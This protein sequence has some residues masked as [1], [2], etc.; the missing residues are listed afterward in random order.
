MTDTAESTPWKALLDAWDQQQSGYLLHRERRFAAVLDA[1][2]HAVDS[3][4]ESAAP[5]RILDLGCGPGSFS[6]R[7][8]TR[9]PDAE[10]VALDIDPVLLAIGQGA[11]GD[12]DGRLTWVD[13][14]LRIPNWHT[15]VAGQPFDAAVSSTALHWLGPAQLTAVYSRLA[16]L[17]RPGGRFLNADN[18]AYDAGLPTLTALARTAA[19]THSAQVFAEGT[20]DWDRWWDEVAAVP[21]LAAAR[22]EK[23]RRAEQRPAEDFDHVALTGLT[24]LRLHVAALREAGFTEVDTIWQHHD[25]RILLAVRGPQPA[26]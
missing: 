1:L 26:G 18:L 21:E 25:D 11:L 16:R 9:F 20:P 19:D 15:Q 17:T 6:A 23:H 4:G 8:L 3:E 13:A 14:D 12:A 24:T 7:L 2:S 22:T 5:Q 10:V